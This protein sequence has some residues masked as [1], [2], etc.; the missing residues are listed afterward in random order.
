MSH[1]IYL[2]ESLVQCFFL[3]TEFTGLLKQTGV[4]EKALDRVSPQ[5]SV[6]VLLCVTVQA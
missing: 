2:S 3:N 5:V 6:E 1:F 4:A